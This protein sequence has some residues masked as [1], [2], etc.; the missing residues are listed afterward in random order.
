MRWIVLHPD[1]QDDAFATIAINVEF[2][3]ATDNNLL[4]YYRK[5]WAVLPQEPDTR[6]RETDA[7][8]NP[9]RA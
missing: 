5:P 1:Y 4:R 6:R 8:R 7:G 2:R 3:W 9:V